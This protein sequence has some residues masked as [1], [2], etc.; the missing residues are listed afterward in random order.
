MVHAG[1]GN[2][3]EIEERFEKSNDYV[4]IKL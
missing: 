2:I 4:V 3:F 1:M